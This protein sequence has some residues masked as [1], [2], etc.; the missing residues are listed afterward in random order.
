MIAKKFI[1]SMEVLKDIAG[2]LTLWLMSHI[3]AA[4]ENK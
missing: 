4:K 2:L 1:L 3:Y